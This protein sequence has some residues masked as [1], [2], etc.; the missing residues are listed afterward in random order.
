[1][2][3]TDQCLEL[4]QQNM[5]YIQKEY[6]VTGM[7]VF[8]S[9]A[10]G[11]TREDSDIDI[12]VDMPPKISLLVSLNGYLE[13]LLNSTVDLVRRHSHMSQKFLKSIERDAI[14]VL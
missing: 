2:C 9:L 14:T 5:P 11:A 4:L 10:R 12:I 3:T 6:G 7:C 8:G 1:M 13:N